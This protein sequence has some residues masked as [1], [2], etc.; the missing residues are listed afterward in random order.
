MNKLSTS[1]VSP[2]QLVRVT[3]KRAL[4]NV[5]IGYPDWSDEPRSAPSPF[6]GSNQSTHNN[7]ANSHGTNRLSWHRPEVTSVV[8]SNGTPVNSCASDSGPMLH[9]SPPPRTHSDGIVPRGH[10]VSNVALYDNHVHNGNDPL[11]AASYSFSS[12]HGQPLCKHPSQPHVPYHHNHNHLHHHRN[13]QYPNPNEHEESTKLNHQNQRLRHHHSDTHQRQPPSYGNGKKGVQQRQKRTRV[14]R[15]SHL[16]MALLRW[17]KGGEKHQQHDYNQHGDGA[18][19]YGDEQG[20]EVREDYPLHVPQ[21]HQSREAHQEARSGPVNND[22]DAAPQDAGVSILQPLHDYYAPLSPF[23]RNEILDAVV[24][25]TNSLRA[26]VNDLIFLTAVL[27]W[28]CSS[29]TVNSASSKQLLALSL[30]NCKKRK[31]Y[32]NIE[33]DFELWFARFSQFSDVVLYGMEEYLMRYVSDALSKRDVMLSRTTADV[34]AEDGMS[35]VEAW[36]QASTRLFQQMDGIRSSMADVDTRLMWLRRS[37]SRNAPKN[38]NNN[39]GYDKNHG[40]ESVL[41]VVVKRVVPETLG[42]LEDVESSIAEFAIKKGGSS[43]KAMVE[44]K[45]GLRKM[46]QEFSVLLMKEGCSPALGWSAVTTLTRWMG[47]RRI[48]NEYVRRL[49]KAGRLSMFGRYRADQSHHAIVKVHQDMAADLR[50]LVDGE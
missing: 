35:R 37:R 3:P 32:S 44:L 18:G 6:F 2:P 33:V 29:T 10:T 41:D 34:E 46:V 16:T 47:E 42:F 12:P 36:A 45:K 17:N 14:R 5:G 40:W 23:G 27:Q 49:A 11:G 15:A 30:M 7:A 20:M 48:K 1:S 38:H 22:R 24:L 31:V 39:Q 8:D 19:F 21:D 9:T 26:E 4:T 13:R 50:R 43:N 28:S 25:F